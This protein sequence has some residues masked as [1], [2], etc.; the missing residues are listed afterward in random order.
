MLNLT[1]EISTRE[2]KDVNEELRQILEINLQKPEAET[3][4]TVHVLK[5]LNQQIIFPAYYVIKY[6]LNTTEI[7]DKAKTW[8]I[9]IT[10]SD[11]KVILAHRKGQLIHTPVDIQ[12]FIGEF[13]WE[14]K[15]IFNATG[16]A[17]NDME[18]NILK[19]EIKEEKVEDELKLQL[20][21]E[22]IL[23]IKQ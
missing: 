4:P 5:S 1:S 8:R 14:L 18:I 13:E 22:L 9:L 21:K 16:T 2:Y 20:Y 6:R 23:G 19:G 3:S 12:D 15:I 7:K 10:L 11:D 17:I